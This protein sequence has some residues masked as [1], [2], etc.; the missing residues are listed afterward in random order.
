MSAPAHPLPE[1]GC[2]RKPALPDR[3][4]SVL[5]TVC[6]RA[7]CS[8]A[9]IRGGRSPCRSSSPANIPP[10]DCRFHHSPLISPRLQAPSQLSALSSQPP[11][12]PW[13][14]VVY[15]SRDWL[16]S[17]RAW[18]TVAAVPLHHHHLDLLVQLRHQPGVRL[19]HDMRVQRLQALSVD[20]QDGE[21]LL[22]ATASNSPPEDE[23]A[24]LASRLPSVLYQAVPMSVRSAAI[25]TDRT[26]T[27]VSSTY[28]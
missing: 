12:T 4:H 17:S 15:L 20:A 28:D 25:A 3:I 27:P 7:Y 13:L 1:P 16:S 8:C 6:V 10:T 23:P 2:G 19:R 22:P 9:G 21:R 18:L 5:T 24:P 11:Q 14:Y 26:G